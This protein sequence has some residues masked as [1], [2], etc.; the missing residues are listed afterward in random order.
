MN[1]KNPIGLNQKNSE[2]I[3]Y[4]LNILLAD[5]QIFY[6]NLRA[7]HWLMLGVIPLHTYENYLGSSTLSAV[8]SVRSG[9]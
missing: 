3:T 7:F 4:A 1:N 6:Q 2:Q 9:N 8:S 5:H